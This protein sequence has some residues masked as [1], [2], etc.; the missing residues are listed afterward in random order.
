MLMLS[1]IA[2]VGAALLVT[3]TSAQLVDLGPPVLP[4]VLSAL[5]DAYKPLLSGFAQANLPATIG[6]C[7]EA[8][9]PANCTDIGNL[10]NVKN[11]FYRVKV[12][13][14]SGINTMR[15]DDIAVT[16][17][18]KD[19]SM[20]L[21]VKVYFAQLP[22][23]F[24]V[25]ACAGVLG[26]STFLDTTKSCCGTAKTVTMTATAKCSERPPFLHSFVVGNATIS[27]GI[28]FTIDVF[29]HTFKVADI[30]S[31][32]I[33]GVKDS[34]GKFLA[35][36]G[37]TLVNS[38]LQSIFGDKVYCSRSSRDADK[39]PLS[40][41]TMPPT[42][43][44]DAPATTGPPNAECKI[45]FPEDYS[46]Q[47][48]ELPLGVVLSNLKAALE[49]QGQEA[50]YYESVMEFIAQS[51][52]W[53]KGDNGSDE[54]EATVVDLTGQDGDGSLTLRFCTKLFGNWPLPFTFPLVPVVVDNLDVL[55]LKLKDIQAE[56]VRL[57][58]ETADTKQ[59]ILVVAM[60]LVLWLSIKY[61]GIF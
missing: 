48:V 20:A 19:G 61:L 51:K 43:T 33:Q 8:N 28:A 49:A 25:E 59:A 57:E 7:K 13:W 50:T 23:S 38:Q 56:L 30:T 46:P 1:T 36:Q 55:D 45:F 6:N 27:P 32:I 53:L 17:D 58:G 5:L 52:E 44:P 35:T 26:C 16:F 18:D 12:R 29:G 2:S 41:V 31:Y 15:L 60:A 40:P 4:D 39:P 34:A 54:Y 37:L 14:I 24:L 9:A 10:Y 47:G 3:M 42:M 22:A 11:T 21:T